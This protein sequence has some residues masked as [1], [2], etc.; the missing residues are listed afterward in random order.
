MFNLDREANLFLE[1]VVTNDEASEKTQPNCGVVEGNKCLLEDT[2]ERRTL[3]QG[4][5]HSDNKNKLETR[6]RKLRTNDS[7][8]RELLN[9]NQITII[10]VQVQ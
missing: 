2:R 10:E 3:C 7:C 5:I 4:L 9:R 8:V 6:S 1:F